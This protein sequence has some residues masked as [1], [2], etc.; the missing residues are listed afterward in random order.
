M[1]EFM[2]RDNED[3]L[4]KEKNMYKL[5]R[6]IHKYKEYAWKKSENARKRAKEFSVKFHDIKYYVSYPTWFEEENV[7]NW[8][9]KNLMKIIPVMYAV[10]KVILMFLKVTSYYAFIRTEKSLK[11]M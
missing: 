11:T 4:E 5:L 3:I 9:K 2:L 6:D 8:Y 1:N 7:T 10:K